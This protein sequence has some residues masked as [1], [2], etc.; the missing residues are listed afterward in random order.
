MH[1]ILSS[2]VLKYLADLKTGKTRSTTA[3]PTPTKPVKPVSQTSQVA[4]PVYEDIPLTSMRQ[5]IAKRLTL[6]KVQYY[7]C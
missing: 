7:Y 2:D 3:Q 4:N 6:S 1:C 5:A